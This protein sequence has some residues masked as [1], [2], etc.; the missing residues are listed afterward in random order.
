MPVEIVQ[1]FEVKST[2]IAKELS[3]FDV[4]NV[5]EPGRTGDPP[6]IGW[7][8]R[9]RATVELNKHSLSFFLMM[10]WTSFFLPWNDFLQSRK[11]LSVHCRGAIGSYCSRRSSRSRRDAHFFLF[12]KSREERVGFILSIIL[13][14]TI[15]FVFESCFC[16]A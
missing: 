2:R 11:L 1:T 16:A 12:T 15:L 7:N 14:F 5:A 10:N 8:F 3:L 13:I 4:N 9:Q 6:A